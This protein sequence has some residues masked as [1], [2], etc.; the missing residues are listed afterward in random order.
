VRIFVT[1]GTGLVGRHLIAALVERKDAVVCIS[2]HEMRARSLLPVGVEVVVADPCEPGP[3]QDVVADCDAVVNLAGESLADGRWTEPRKQLFRRSRLEVTRNLAAAIG[4]DEAPGVLVSA[5]ATGY[6]GNGG[7]RAL[8]ETCEP[9]HDFLA[10]LAREWE[11]TALRAESAATRVVL[12]RIGIVLTHEGGALPRLVLP[13]RLGLGGPLGNGRQYFPWVHI[14]DL[15]KIIL[16]ALDCSDLYGPVN[17]VAPDPPTQRS[18]ARALGS[19]LRRPS[20]LPV[21]A[22]LI[23]FLLGQKSEM[24]LASQRAV[25]KALRARGF[26]FEFDHIDKALADLLE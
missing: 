15:T 11:G 24:V 6:Y 26:R 16:F 5:S 19:T 17:A 22:F 10:R 4:R 18:F 9:G 23:R 20:L 2:R 13:Y 14:K 3:W 7:D 25:P 21:P 1:G 8:D 12:L